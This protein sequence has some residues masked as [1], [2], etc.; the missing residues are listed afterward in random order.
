MMRLF[1]VVILL[2]LTFNTFSQNVI[3]IENDDI[4]RV[5][6][7]IDSE[8]IYIPSELME[9][10]YVYDF[11]SNLVR[12]EE[13]KEILDKN[14]TYFR[15]INDQFLFCMDNTLMMFDNTGELISSET[16][17]IGCIPTYISVDFNYVNVMIP[18]LFNESEHT[19]VYSS[20]DLSFVGSL[21]PGVDINYIIYE[22]EMVPA[23]ASL[24]GYYGN[25]YLLKYSNGTS[26]W[27]NRDTNRIYS[28]SDSIIEE[29]YSLDRTEYVHLASSSD[30]IYYMQNEEE[31]TKIISIEL[32]K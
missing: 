18:K 31:L 20:S 27:I 22:D 6:F 19:L 28:F 17:P 29:V 13:I 7:D 5:F 25:N 4:N 9:L 16:F 32:Y 15:Q 26:Y 3:T 8:Y 12:V 14:V 2:L 10:I 1:C 23:V 21:K 11:D 30:Q 24:D